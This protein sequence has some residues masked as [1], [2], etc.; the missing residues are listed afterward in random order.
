MLRV[1]NMLQNIWQDKECH[2]IVSHIMCFA[3]DMKVSITTFNHLSLNQTVI[4]DRYKLGIQSSDMLH[5]IG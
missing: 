4:I 3:Y 1:S 2:R 5:S